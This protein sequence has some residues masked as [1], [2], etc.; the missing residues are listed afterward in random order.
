MALLN[1]I[2][3]ESK[4]SNK[5]KESKKSN[6]SLTK[7]VALQK[8]H[9]TPVGQE[10]CTIVLNLLSNGICSMDK[11]S[12]LL[13]HSQI[14][15]PELTLFQGVPQCRLPVDLFTYILG[16]Q[17]FAPVLLQLA[18]KDMISIIYCY[19]RMGQL[20]GFQVIRKSCTSLQMFVG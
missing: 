16:V 18:I 11:R 7:T 9:L 12:L 5:R 1:W 17:S 14:L 4:K 20:T 3:K 2:V 15:L 10:A 19:N 6:N 13:R 8:N